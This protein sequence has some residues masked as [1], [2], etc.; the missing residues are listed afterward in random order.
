M[1]KKPPVLKP[2]TPLRSSSRR[3]F[4]AHL[5][6]L[7]PVL[8][9]ASPEVIQQVVPNGLKQCNATTSADQKAV[10]YSSDNGRP[11]WFEVGPNA[12]EALQQAQKKSDRNGKQAQRENLAE[13]IP[14]VYV[15]W[16]V[17]NLL[18]RLPTW[19]Q[20]VDPTLLAGSSLMIPG[21]IPAPHTFPEGHESNVY[22]P[23][24]SL[25]AITAYPE[26]VPLVLARLELDMKVICSKR[27]SGEKGKA[28]ST[29]HAMGDCLWEMG[30]KGAP[31]SQEETQA[32]VGRLTVSNIN[33][34]GVKALGLHLED[35]SIVERSRETAQRGSEATATQDR[36][37]ST[38]N[39]TFTFT[40]AEVDAL[41]HLSLLQSLA[42]INKQANVLPMPVSSLYS[43][44]VLPNRPAHWPPRDGKGRSKSRLARHLLASS[45]EDND[46]ERSVNADT[47]DVKGTSAR[48]LVKWIKN[49][50]KSEILK[51]K[52]VKGKDTVITHIN[53]SH[54]DF[55]ALA[56]YYTIAQAQQN[57][58]NVDA[59]HDL[60]S[61]VAA[62]KTTV[63]IEKFWR[64][65]ASSVKLFQEM[66]ASTSEPLSQPVIRG[67]LSDYIASHRL[68]DANS[69]AYIR[70]E[71]P[72]LVHA[73]YPKAQLHEIPPLMTRQ[74]LIDRLLTTSCVEFHRSSRLESNRAAV[75]QQLNTKGQ[76]VNGGDSSAH[77]EPLLENE[78]VGQVTKGIAKLVTI[79]I[80]TRQGRKVV[81]L[82]TA[83]EVYGMDPHVLAHDLM[84]VG[85][86]ASAT[87][88]P[89]STPKNPK[90]EVFVQGDQRKA[91][92]DFVERHGLD[93][94][95]VQVQ[96]ST[97]K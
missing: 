80:K 54:A 88:L 28:A 81:T 76:S 55:D 38:G 69:Q 84:K 53:S 51:C 86:S 27:A 21:L 15:L 85:A 66:G 72:I 14:T 19:P 36:R 10:I 67:R 12:G 63:V 92:Y 5:Q 7:Y 24:S 49:A 35:T 22:P 3:G 20:I 41:M 33:D 13:I 65:S 78:F 34:E 74:E 57:P 1:F 29:L 40:V 82:I 79:E 95:F 23:S 91:V 11:L 45:E 62:P 48:K 60:K 83:L 2:S 58:T 50:E 18:P 9:N 71:D 77:L 17:P 39:T 64:A 68:V 26:A 8:K 87:A 52:E 90:Y 4:L 16:I 61:S 59:D 31:P 94:R 75:V 37:D 46:V 56:P 44:H 70:L 42:A 43:A 73:L 47:V 30:G 97:K 89:S 93:R 32:R 6:T 96:D 25:V